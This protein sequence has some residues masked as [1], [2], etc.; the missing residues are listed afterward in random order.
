MIVQRYSK[1]NDFTQLC[2]WYAKRDM[3]PTLELIP[4]IG[5]IVPGIAA[6]FFMSTDTTCCILE[7]FVTNPDASK[8]DRNEA[9]AVIMKNLLTLAKTL[10]FTH[11]FGFTNNEKMAGRCLDLGFKIVEEKGVTLCKDL[12]S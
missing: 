6:G 7:P 11:V 4:T 8:A 10:G 12:N 1:D 3:K 2:E 5:F 9:L